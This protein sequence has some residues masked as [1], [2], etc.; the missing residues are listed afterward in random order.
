MLSARSH[1]RYGLPA[2]HLEVNHNDRLQDTAQRT[3]AEVDS[4]NYQYVN[5]EQ[6]HNYDTMSS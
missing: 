5:T 4:D 2:H 1:S 3:M 6:S